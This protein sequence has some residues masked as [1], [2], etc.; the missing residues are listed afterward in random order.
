MPDLNCKLGFFMS[1]A[2]SLISAHKDVMDNLTRFNDEHAEVLSQAQATAPNCAGYMHMLTGM[3]VVVG[4][5]YLLLGRAYRSA[6]LPPSVPRGVPRECYRNAGAL[7][8]DSVE[9]RYAYCEGYA[10]RGGLIPVHHA[11]CLDEQGC[12]VDPTWPHDEKSEYLGVALSR[13]ALLRNCQETGTWGVLSE[14]LANFVVEQHPVDY[15]HSKWR[16]S[17]A[18]CNAFWE[19]LKQNL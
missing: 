13:D 19:K 11:W 3:N 8:I 12:V 10:M 7:V 6:P 16:P 18:R 2:D 5:F 15:L 17:D 4:H 14:R 9:P 1:T